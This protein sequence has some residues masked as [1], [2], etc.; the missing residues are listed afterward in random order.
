MKYIQLILKNVNILLIFE[1]FSFNHQRISW[2][3]L[4]DQQAIEFFA[5]LM[6]LKFL[7]ELTLNLQ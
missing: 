7:K 4:N 2:D 1:K 5:F 3:S 6:K